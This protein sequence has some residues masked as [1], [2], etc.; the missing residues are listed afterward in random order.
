MSQLKLICK[1]YDLH[2]EI[3]ITQLIFFEENHKVSFSLKKIIILNDE[4]KKENK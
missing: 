1:I 4:I 2:H 3:E